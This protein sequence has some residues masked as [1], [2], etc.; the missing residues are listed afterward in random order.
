MEILYLWIDKYK[1]IEKKGFNFSNKFMFSFCEESK[2][3]S[4]ELK[5]RVTPNDFF[6]KYKDENFGR[7]ANVTAIVGENGSGK[8][9]LLEFIK[10]KISA[11]LNQDKVELLLEENDF[12]KD[13]GKLV[14]ITGDSQNNDDIVTIYC[15]NIENINTIG[16]DDL[17]IKVKFHLTAEILNTDYRFLFYSSIFDAKIHEKPPKNVIDISTNNLAE[18]AVGY[19]RDEIKRQLLFVCS[20]L[21]DELPIQFPESVKC[22]M[23]YKF[24]YTVNL[25]PIPKSHDEFESLMVDL[26]RARFQSVERIHGNLLNEK[27]IDIYIPSK[28]IG[29]ECYYVRKSRDIEFVDFQNKI[30]DGIEGLVSYLKGNLIYKDNLEYRFIIATTTQRNIVLEKY[31]E[32]LVNK[33]NRTN[34]KIEIIYWKDIVNFMN[35]ETDILIKYYKEWSKFKRETFDPFDYTPKDNSVKS[36]LINS[37]DER[38]LCE[39]PIEKIVYDVCTAYF[40]IFY[41][42]NEKKFT[43]SNSQYSCFFENMNM[44]KN[45]RINGI[46]EFFKIVA[47]KDNK[48]KSVEEKSDYEKLTKFINQFKILYEKEVITLDYNKSSFYKRIEMIDKTRE[49]EFTINFDKG[50]KSDYCEFIGEIYKNLSVVQGESFDFIYFDWYDMSS[51][52]KAMIN[53]FARFYSTIH[54]F[55]DNSNLIVLID[56]GESYF[57][58]G[59]QRLYFNMLLNIL[60]QIYKKQNI[61]IILT[62]NSPFLV[63]DIPNNNIIFLKRN[64]D[65]T[66]SIE[67]SFDKLT[68]GANIY[69]LLAES[70]FMHNEFTGEFSKEKIQQV[71]DFIISESKDDSGNI[72]NNELARF[73][74][75]IIGEPVIKDSLLDALK[76]K[77][78][79]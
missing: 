65:G 8:S 78:D 70:F 77:E 40:L 64:K 14:L 42:R 1:N 10:Y 32:N 12:L 11:L 21:A 34:I 2:S 26:Y 47:N 51:G 29:V 23:N 62:T 22:Q 59:W 7:I 74:I 57:H 72:M 50:I 35:Q 39:T 79:D 15:E 20:D 13:I 25:P 66:V 5:K 9:A 49:I 36:F 18:Y 33:I 73:I 24:E 43:K 37:E 31:V 17:N 61:Q 69:E 55:D 67:E 52:Q 4:V 76:E 41:R 71:V 16:F 53:L 63:S 54:N 56:E 75:D 27:G 45:S 58:P 28:R 38:S 6:C 3:L 68:F 44:S 19:R 30:V 60:P 46:I 48:F